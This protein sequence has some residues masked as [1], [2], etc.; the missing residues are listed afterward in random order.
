MSH[1]L[2][3]PQKVKSPVGPLLAAV[4]LVLAVLWL[5]WATLAGLLSSLAKSDDYSYGLLLPVVAAYIVYLKWPQIRRRAWRPSWLGLLVMAAGLGLYVAGELAAELYTTR[6]SFVVTLAGV[7]MLLGGYPLA[8]LLAFPLLLLVLMIPLPELVTYKLTLP[9]QLLSSRLAADFLQVA[10]IPVFRQGN[11]IDLG[12]RQ[13]QV[14]DACSGMRYILALLALGIIFCYFFQR[15]P[16]KAAILLLALIPA[17]IFANALRVAGMGIFPALL[18]GFW[19]SFSGWLIFLV[20]L[21]ILASLNWG[22]NRLSPPA[23]GPKTNLPPPGPPPE[24]PP[25]FHWPKV[26]AA[27]ALVIL[28]VPLMQR[29]AQAPNVPLRQSLDLFPMEMAGWQGRHAYVDPEEVAATRSHAHL[30]AE[31]AKPDLGRV[32][33]WIAYYETQKKAGGFVHSPKGCLTASGWRILEAKVLKMAPGMPVNYLLVEQ[34]GNRLVVYYWFLQRGRWLTS[35][36]MN[37]FYMAFDGLT[38]RRTDGALIRLITPDTGGITEAQER[39]NNF[40]RLLAPVL[41]DYIPN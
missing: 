32:S 2:A 24:G 21:S 23:P 40:G 27:L 8:R 19:H 13:M 37:K 9:L 39:L 29:A 34:R 38:R 11:I 28:S 5:Y 1:T 15:R 14:V 6:F 41:H 22:L 16:W 10:G 35:E 3:T 30:N 33:L 12:V 25:Q 36:I 17:A 26:L 4:S 18:T 7:V 31:Y 20:S